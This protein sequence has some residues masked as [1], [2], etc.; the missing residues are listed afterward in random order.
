MDLGIKDKVAL[1]AAASAGLGKASALALAAE[2]AQIAICGRDQKKLEQAKREI[3]NA[4]SR[5]ILAIRADVAEAAEVAQ[6]VDAVL[7]KYGTVH[8]LVNN[9]GG[10]PPGVFEQM[11]DAEWE[12]AFELTL[13]SS[14][15]LT[16][17]VLPHMRR[18]KWGRV[19]NITSMSVKQPINDLVLSNS[20][21]LGV[22]GWAK[23]LSNQV[24]AD[25]IT[26]NNVCPG[27]TLTDRITSL[28]AQRAG[29][30]GRDAK[31]VEKE[32]TARVPAGRMGQPEEFAR[33]VAFLASERAAYITGTSI[34]ID[35]GV[36]AG[37]F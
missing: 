37:Y 29:A 4:A 34:H 25:G 24:A 17:A 11:G 9:A 6:F 2:G 15:R 16:R 1:V 19:I 10:P 27:Y 32:M 14:V 20:L 18:Q 22:V 30:S 12:K 3:E 28:L 13:M 8:I 26:I 23:T 7:A 21:R 31:D 35:G 33:L 5:E 36:T